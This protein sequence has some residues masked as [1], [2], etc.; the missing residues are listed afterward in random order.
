MYC[1]VFSVHRLYWLIWRNISNIYT[2]RGDF[3]SSART[4]L[5][6]STKFGELIENV[7]VDFGVFWCASLPVEP[8]PFHENREK[9]LWAEIFLSD[10]GLMSTSPHVVAVDY[11]A[12]LIFPCI[13]FM[14]TYFVC[15]VIPTVD[16]HR[17]MVYAHTRHNNKTQKKRLEKL[18]A[19]R[20]FLR[21]H[22]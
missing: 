13:H 18:T 14:H 15:T 3:Q 5:N 9:S 7:V 20:M 4:E 12:L 2:P 10:Y 17:N 21:W 19:N 16:M 6:M 1:I 8:L 22:G 11:S